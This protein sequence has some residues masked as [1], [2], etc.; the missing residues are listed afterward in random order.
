MTG[1][2]YG[3]SA[4]AEDPAKSEV[5]QFTTRIAGR[6]V[7]TYIQLFPDSPLKNPQL[8]EQIKKSNLDH[9]L[10]YREIE[11]DG[12]RSPSTNEPAD[13]LRTKIER[14]TNTPVLDIKRKRNLFKSMK[15]AWKLSF[16]SAERAPGRSD[17][18][19]GLI[20]TVGESATFT[21]LLIADG[22]VALANGAALV[23]AQTMLSYINNVHNNAIS[24]F[25]NANWYEAKK[26]A[27][28][29]T[30]YFR[31]YVY[32][33]I[34]S[35]MF[36]AI[37]DPATFLS[38]SNQAMIA[39]NSFFAGSG[40]MLAS[41]AVFKEFNHDKTKLAKVNF[42]INFIG[43]ALGSFD[44]ILHNS[45]PTIIHMQVYDLTL[46]GVILIGYY[47]AAVAAVKLMPNK[48][49]SLISRFDQTMKKF[50]YVATPRLR[51]CAAL[52][53]TDFNF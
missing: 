11:N 3:N 42:Y 35:Q 16:K 53:P 45:M 22:N 5:I 33:W 43:T 38:A 28:L 17:R 4:Y 26:D 37:Q 47:A 52:L 9:V 14:E 48:V 12:S 6:P 39:M 15:E 21:A 20:S 13:E 34:T 8:I 44:L 50:R 24:N 41:N 27:R 18:Y 19:Y 25:L 31:S 30:I 32:D 10:F 40:D 7:V 1:F 46:S 49:Y 23:A 29:K 36:K 51:N 2:L